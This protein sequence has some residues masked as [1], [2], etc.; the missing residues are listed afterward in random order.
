M[1]ES[2]MNIGQRFR[3]VKLML[4]LPL[5]IPKSLKNCHL[6]MQQISSI[7]A[8]FPINFDFCAAI[9]KGFPC[10]PPRLIKS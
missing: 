4:N 5:F 1:Q 10:W 7:Y 2:I 8:L 9:L 6:T 3:V